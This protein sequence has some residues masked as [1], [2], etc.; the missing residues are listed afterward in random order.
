MNIY[1]LG[2][3]VW[4][5]EYSLEV[6]DDARAVSARR[7]TLAVITPSFDTRHGRLV[8]L[9]QEVAG[10]VQRARLGLGTGRRHL[11]HNHVTEVTSA[12]HVATAGQ[13]LECRDRAAV[14]IFHDVEQTA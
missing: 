5:E 12:D 6:P 14:R 4:T 10:H 3:G 11:P 1:F 2:H 7:Y 9:Q 13:R 8:F